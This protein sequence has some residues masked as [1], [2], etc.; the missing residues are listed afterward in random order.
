MSAKTSSCSSLTRGRASVMPVSQS[1]VNLK[2][3]PVA[4]KK[5][6]K[7]G[8]IPLRSNHHSHII[9]TGRKT[10]G[11]PDRIKSTLA[12]NQSTSF[13]RTTD[14][15]TEMESERGSLK[16]VSASLDNPHLQK[17][18][19]FSQS[20]VEDNSRRPTSQNQNILNIETT[21]A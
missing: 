21:T 13:N 20:L 5:N 6:G 14:T 8:G 16:Y 2:A 9:P 17:Q 11:A 3:A 1:L 7:K 12:V 15:I 10:T 19:T 18:H 4:K